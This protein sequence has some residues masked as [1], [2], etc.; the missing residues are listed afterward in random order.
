MLREY[1]KGLLI[2]F[3][4]VGIYGTGVHV[5]DYFTLDNMEE[6]AIVIS[7][8]KWKRTDIV[9][10]SVDDHNCA[11]GKK[12]SVTSKNANQTVF[13]NEYCFSK[14]S[15]FSFSREAD[16]VEQVQSKDTDKSLLMLDRTIRKLNNTVSFAS[17][18]FGSR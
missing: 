8:E 2:A 7:H 5:K 3:V 11:S 16:I 17:D 14:P 4:A 12:W 15:V 9:V 1:M 18:L 6:K 13:E 10:T